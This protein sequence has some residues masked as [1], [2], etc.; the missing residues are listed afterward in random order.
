ML[1]KISIRALLS[2]AAFSL[3]A[4]SDDY[5]PKANATGKRIYLEACA[6]CHAAEPGTTDMYWTIDV[7]N[8]NATYVAHKVHT[9]SLTMPSFPN[10]KG[11]K[12]RQLG[13]FVLSHSL[14][15]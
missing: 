4:C 14:R 8:A 9:G 11:A 7:K 15:K 10:I 1:W 12:M 13:E 5:T 3:A 6:T 2:L